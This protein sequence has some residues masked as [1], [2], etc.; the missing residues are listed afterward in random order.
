M[1]LLL[2]V[3]DPP[4]RDSRSLRRRRVYLGEGLRFELLSRGAAIETEAIDLTSAGLGLAVVH[5]AALPQ[6]GEI[7]SV[8]S[9]GRCTSDSAQPAVVRNVGTLRRGERVLPRIGLELV[10]DTSRATGVERRGPARYRCPDALPAFATAACAWFFR[11]QLHFRIVRVGAGGMTLRCSRPDAPVFA[12]MELDFDL[13]LGFVAVVPANGRL[14][15]VR[16]DGSAVEVG[17]S[18]V[19][20]PSTLFKTLS[21]YLLAAHDTLNPARLRAGGLTVE[22]IERAVTYDCARSSAD[23]E[24]ILALRLLA[25]QAEGHLDGVSINDLR[26]PFDAHARHLTCR[27][28]GRIV[29]YVRVI[30]VD[31][32]PSRSQY[33]TLGGHEVP[34]WLWEAGFVEAGAGAMHPDFQRAGLFVPLMAHAVRVAVQSGH[35]FVLGACDDG[36]LG[37]YSEMGFEL[38]ES[39]V[40][41]PKSGWRFRSHLI[42]LDA[43]RLLR[44][45]PASKTLAAMASAVDFAGLPAV[46]EDAGVVIHQFG[47]S[48][49][50]CR[51]AGRGRAR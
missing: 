30:F 51:G 11:E 40:V 20:P 49:V 2:P 43:E 1:R 17:V 26:S 13:H 5:T 27:R 16:W 19:D 14:T 3:T 28:G 44:E 38:L 31:G 21:H 4:G 29:G 15:S 34:P 18:W 9:T 32:I 22:S 25:H 24:Q 42:Y 46:A 41:E 12:G 7:V 39:R 33:V 23:Y 6:V 45:P 36:L 50:R 37:M 10:L 35:R 8:R 47:G 48:R